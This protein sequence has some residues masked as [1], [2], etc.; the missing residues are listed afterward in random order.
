MLTFAANNYALTPV[1]VETNDNQKYDTF[2]EYLQEGITIKEMLTDLGP[3]QTDLFLPAISSTQWK[4]IA[5]LL[6][7]AYEN[8][9]TTIATLLTNANNPE[10][11]EIVT[12]STFLD[13]QAIEKELLNELEKRILSTIQTFIETEKPLQYNPFNLNYDMQ[14]VVAQK[15]VENYIPKKFDLLTTI[16]K[17]I[18]GHNRE[19]TTVAFNPKKPMLASGSENFDLK[20]WN[21]SN[22][23]NSILLQTFDK[24]NQGHIQG[25]SIVVFN[26]QGTV[27]ASGSYDHTI[28]LW[29]VSNPDKIQ[30]LTTLDK[31]YNSHTHNVQSLAFNPQGTILASASNDRTIKLWDVTNPKKPNLLQTIDQTNNGHTSSVTSLAFNPQGTLLI[32]GELSDKTIKIWDVTNPQQAKLLKTIDST[33]NGHTKGIRSLVFNSQG[34]IF[35]SA[36]DDTTT[37]IWNVNDPKNPTLLQTIHNPAD[38]LSL[39]FA[40]KSSILALVLWNAS[41]EIWDLKNPSK[42]VLLQ[43]IDK[44]KD[45]HSTPIYSVA[46]NTD[47]SMFAS[48]SDDNSIKLWSSKHKSLLETITLPQALLLYYGAQK[49]GIN[50]AGKLNLKNVFNTLS[51]HIKEYIKPFVK[52]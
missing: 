25:V 49:G 51:P 4:I 50:I 52:D 39:A 3:T 10:F 26:P 16:D 31:T 44:N 11:K 45:G 19:V 47:G 34:K 17:K 6:K 14:K 30:L 8:D 46:F 7:A 15:I 5:P 2:V 22:P 40:P 41:I 27:L 18:G 35:A 9:Q 23:K 37:K 33:N 12:I 1:K 36:S 13:I 42:P 29:D 38:V 21:I 43:K 24:D 48:G 32:S 28:K 20:I